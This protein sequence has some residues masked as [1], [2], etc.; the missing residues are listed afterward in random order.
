M[1]RDPRQHWKENEGAGCGLNK[2]QNWWVLCWGK[3]RRQRS[4]QIWGGIRRQKCQQRKSQHAQE[5]DLSW[6]G[7][8]L[9]NPISKHPHV[10][11]AQ[12]A[13]LDMA[14][15]IALAWYLLFAWFGGHTWQSLLVF[16]AQ[17]SGSSYSLQVS[18]Y[19]QAHAVLGISLE[20]RHLPNK[21]SP[22]PSRICQVW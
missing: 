1:R 11:E 8:P 21:L 14:P 17:C 3:G 16:L 13:G 7:A 22:W 10:I 20:S 19:L 12:H 9:Q 4:R 2:T 5:D 15:W 6:T 18:W